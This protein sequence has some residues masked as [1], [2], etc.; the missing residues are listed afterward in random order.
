VNDELIAARSAS[1]GL[2][3][4]EALL[5][6]LDRAVAGRV[7]VISAPPGSGKTSLLRTWLDRFREDRSVA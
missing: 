6:T 5:A 2:L 3:R 1:Q 4:R 7:T